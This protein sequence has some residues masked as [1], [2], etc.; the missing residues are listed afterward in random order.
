MVSKKEYKK[1]KKRSK[2]ALK[3]AQICYA[4]HLEWGSVKVN[5]NYEPH[6][7]VS[8]IDYRGRPIQIWWQ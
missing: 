4:P 5:P 1:I 7:H 6:I 8:Q 3:P 2:R